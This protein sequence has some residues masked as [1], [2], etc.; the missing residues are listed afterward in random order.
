[1][2]FKG[3]VFVFF[4]TCAAAGCRTQSFLTAEAIGCGNT[5]VDVIESRYTR[6]GTSTAWCAKCK[7]KI[8]HCVSNPDHSRVQCREA[9]AWD[10]CT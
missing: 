8:Y 7:G 3:I 4:L 9:T 5:E 1:M 2:T 6:E 10:P